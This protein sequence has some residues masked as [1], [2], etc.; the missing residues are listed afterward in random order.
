MLARSSQALRSMLHSFYP[1]VSIEVLLRF[2]ANSPKTAVDDYT[3]HLTWRE[4]NPLMTDHDT[5]FYPV[6][7]R[8]RLLVHLQTFFTLSIITT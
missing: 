2:A 6:E 8:H 3:A 7:V 4:A 1:G 5:T